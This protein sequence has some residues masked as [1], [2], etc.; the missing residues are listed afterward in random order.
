MEV[1]SQETRSCFWGQSSNKLSLRN[2]WCISQTSYHHCKQTRAPILWMLS[3][4]SGR[5]LAAKM[6]TDMSDIDVT[7][8]SL[9]K[10]KR[11]AM[12]PLYCQACGA[13]CSQV[14][15][16]GSAWN[17]VLYHGHSPLLREAAAV[18]SQHPSQRK[19][20]CCF[21]SWLYRVECTQD[22]CLQSDA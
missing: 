8:G 9:H 18:S 7:D 22:S 1:G 10:M 16:P 4:K 12:K 3:Y 19:C 2:T 21:A 11:W 6:G 14:A 15:I 13:Q 20:L 17:S 5:D